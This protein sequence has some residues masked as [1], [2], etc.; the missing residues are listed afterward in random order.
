VHCGGGRL[1][2]GVPAVVSDD[3]LSCGRIDTQILPNLCDDTRN[4]C[5]ARTFTLLGI[6][7]ISEGRLENRWALLSPI[8]L[9]QGVI[10]FTK[11]S[12]LP[13]F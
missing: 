4:D 2:E 11:S 13:P 9:L 12:L 7:F 10:V 1:K 8:F 6:S 3:E 5:I